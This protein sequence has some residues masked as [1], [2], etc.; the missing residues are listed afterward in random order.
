MF[1]NALKTIRGQARLIGV[2]LLGIGAVLFLC[3]VAL[4]IMSMRAISDLTDEIIRLEEQVQPLQRAV[5]DMRYDAVQVQQFLSDVSATRALNG[6]DD[7]FKEAERYLGIFDRDAQTAQNLAGQMGLSALADRITNLRKEFPR[8]HA[9]GKVMAEAYVGGGTEAG[10]AKMPAFDKETESI[11]E[12]LDK[13]Q[14]GVVAAIARERGEAKE[15]CATERARIIIFLALALGLGVIDCLVVI[16]VL[17]GLFSAS[18]LLVRAA[19]ALHRASAGDLNARVTQIG[20]DDEIGDLLRNANRVMDISEAFAKEAGTA[21]AYAAKKKYFRHI[22]EDGMRGEFMTYVRRINAV[23]AGM[24]SRDAETI[25]FSEENVVP[26]IESARDNTIALRQSA[27][28]LNSIASQTIERSMVVAAAAEQATVNVQS[29]ASAAT[30]LSAS[31]DEINR[32]MAESSRLADEAVSEAHNTNQIVT[33]LN[34]AAQKIGDVVK[35][36]RDIA[37]QTNLLALN[38][39]IEAARAGDAGKGFA[40]VAGE[41]KNLANQTARATEDITK[42]VGEMQRIA[43]DTVAAIESVGHIITNINGNIGSV[44]DAVHSQGAATA[45][46]SRNVQEAAIGTG[47]VAKNIVAVTEGARETQSMAGVVFQASEGLAGQAAALQRDVST[48]I[49]KVRGA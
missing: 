25:R 32:Q 24:E 14:A 3:S 45:E 44:A 33:G 39:T 4:G 8:F 41:V 5:A 30:E 26:V 7:G 12:S 22:L 34:D 11:T 16:W 28:T 10:N 17:R 38:A 9:A 27:S 35:L 1:G 6:M 40:V 47:E 31:I 49:A 21:M 36:I 19:D 13:A 23:I 2:L 42:Q 46:I 20:R 48:F 43:G 37:D 18:R 15:K 29:V